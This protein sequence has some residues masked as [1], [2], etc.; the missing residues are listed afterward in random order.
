MLANIGEFL[1]NIAEVWGI[2]VNFVPNFGEV[3]RIF[4]NLNKT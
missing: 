4:V 2:F 3:S 1:A